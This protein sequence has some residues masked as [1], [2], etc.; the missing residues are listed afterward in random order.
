[1]KKVFLTKIYTNNIY[2]KIF[3][4]ATLPYRISKA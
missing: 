2:H 4:T 1:M 3:E